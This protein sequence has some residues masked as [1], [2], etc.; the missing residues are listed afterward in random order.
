MRLTSKYGGC[1]DGPCPAIHD[2]DDPEMIAIQGPLLTDA[3]ALSDAGDV[4]DHERLVLIPRR[5]LRGYADG[6]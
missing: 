3:E 2:T 5:L 4:P 1:D 6:R